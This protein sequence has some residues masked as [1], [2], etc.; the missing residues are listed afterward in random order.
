MVILLFLEYS[1]R[2][3]GFWARH[4]SSHLYPSSQEAKTQCCL[5]STFSSLCSHL[6]LTLRPG[7]AGDGG[8]KMYHTL[9]L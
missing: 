7:L 3:K 4:G 6:T 5:L 9:R 2:S 1:V 8:H